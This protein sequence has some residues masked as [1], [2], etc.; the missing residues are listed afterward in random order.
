ML[1][2]YV[3]A[4]ILL[5]LLLLWGLYDVGKFVRDHPHIRL[6]SDLDVFKSLARRNMMAA[7]FGFTLIAVWFLLAILVSREFHWHLKALVFGVTVPVAFLTM[8]GKRIESAA[9]NLPC[10]PSL[11]SEYRRVAETWEHRALPDF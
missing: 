10:A 11:A 8:R 4:S 9:R 1:E 2:A 3:T 6:P 5:V 7:L